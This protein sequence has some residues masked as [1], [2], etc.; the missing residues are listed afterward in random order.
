MTIHRA[1]A[2]LGAL[3][4]LAAASAFAQQIDQDMDEDSENG[5]VSNRQ[6]YPEDTELCQDGTLVRCKAGAWGTVGACKDRPGPAPV[7]Q[8]GDVVDDSEDDSED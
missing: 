7:S 8:G 4:L 3:S 5:C 1:L 6:V 2:I